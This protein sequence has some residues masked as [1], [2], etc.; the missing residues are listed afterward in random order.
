M[1]DSSSPNNGFD[2]TEHIDTHAWLHELLS[3]S[4]ALNVMRGNSN[5]LQL[6]FRRTMQVGLRHVQAGFKSQLA[7]ER[8]RLLHLN[9]SMRNLREE[10]LD[11]EATV[12][13]LHNTIMDMEETTEVL[14]NENLDATIAMNTT[15][16]RNAELTLAM[17][18]SEVTFKRVDARDTQG[19]HIKR[20]M[21]TNP[22]RAKEHLFKNT[23]LN[24][25]DFDT[26]TEDFQLEEEA[27]TKR[28][29]RAAELQQQFR[30]EQQA[31]DVER[32]RHPT[33]TP[34]KTKVNRNQ[35]QFAE[36]ENA[37]QQSDDDVQ[38]EQEQRLD[39]FSSTLQLT[40][41]DAKRVATERY[42][43]RTKMAETFVQD[44]QLLL[45]S[46]KELAKSQRVQPQEILAMVKQGQDHVKIAEMERSNKMTSML[47]TQIK[48]LEVEF[49]VRLNP[50]LRAQ[51]AKAG[52]TE[53]MPLFTKEILESEPINIL[54]HALRFLKKHLSAKFMPYIITLYMVE[55]YSGAHNLCPMPPVSKRLP[56]PYEQYSPILSETMDFQNTALWDDLEHALSTMPALSTESK[57]VVKY[58]NKDAL[59][60][61]AE[62]G[63]GTMRLYSV[64]CLK[65]KPTI[66]HRANIKRHLEHV[67]YSLM[68]KHHP[69]DVAVWAADWIDKGLRMGAGRPSIDFTCAVA[70]VALGLI[71]RQ[72]GLNHWLQKWVAPN[73]EEVAEDALPIMKAFMSDILAGTKSIDSQPNVDAK[74]WK[75]TAET[76]TFTSVVDE[77]AFTTV[78]RAMM[79]TTGDHGNGGSSPAGGGRGRG[80]GRGSFRDGGRGGR[81]RNERN[82]HDTKA[83]TVRCANLECPG[84]D[85]FGRPFEIYPEIRKKNPNIQLCVKCYVTMLRDEVD[86]TTKNGLIKFREPLKRNAR[87]AKGQKI[88]AYVAQVVCGEGAESL[89]TYHAFAMSLPEEDDKRRILLQNFKNVPKSMYGSNETYNDDAEDASGGGESSDIAARL[90]KLE[91]QSS[92]E[93]GGK[94][95]SRFTH[96][97]QYAE[98]A[99]A[100]EPAQDTDAKA[101]QR[102]IEKWFA[103]EAQ[104]KGGDNE[105]SEEGGTFPPGMSLLGALQ[106]REA[107]RQI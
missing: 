25:S 11:N 21:Q 75:A 52:T 56:F 86:V 106:A 47:H 38:P 10:A 30:T 103:L 64:L 31:A 19:K 49:L 16:A 98:L 8:G 57:Q 27:R 88:K 69:I 4:T 45:D 63:D 9:R 105:H 102:M 62:D 1:Q 91:L 78:N 17:Q 24:L 18:A 94:E 66:T 99:D 82:V 71:R 23:G 74:S 90:A 14:R 97:N 70:N 28:R 34:I 33:M 68:M 85:K 36:V 12:N 46:L 60:T 104:S 95:T 101:Q 87:D 77:E 26:S 73:S 96:A 20:A 15:L 44:K 83:T 7:Q 59:S 58:G 54:K 53:N 13:D 92:S 61:L 37:T 22:A 29:Q 48:E 41:T 6:I 35:R 55:S 93:K 65:S 2:G 51:T 43:Y 79:A 107:R 84:I 67:L 39:L 3:D 42:A 5:Q 72:V 32:G 81:D 40:S 100:S 50:E 80:R 89:R 76:V